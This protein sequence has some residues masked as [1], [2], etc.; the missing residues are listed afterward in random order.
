MRKLLVFLLVLVAATIGLG[1]YL[2]WFQ[3][4]TSRETETGRKTIELDIDTK[5]IKTDTETAEKKVGIP[6]EKPK[7][8]TEE[9]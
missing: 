2:D 4:R 8:P 3:I 1:F 5:K 9:K 7:T 6:S